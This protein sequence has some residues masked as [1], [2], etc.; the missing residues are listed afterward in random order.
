VRLK[1]GDAFDVTADKKQTDFKVLPKPTK[2]INTFESAYEITLKNA[3]KEKV[4]VTVQEPISGDWSIVSENIPHRKLNSQLA[5][6]Q[7]DIPAESSTS[8][9]YRARV[10]F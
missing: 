6:W 1:L 4:T 7:V 8:L 5:G 9:T 3:K 2:G 10:K